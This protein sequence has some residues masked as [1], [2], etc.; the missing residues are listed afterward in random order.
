[1]CEKKKK[2]KKEKEKG[3]K[4]KDKRMKVGYKGICAFK[5]R[6]AA[7]FVEIP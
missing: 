2:L 7:P 6:I 4:Y 1:M 5:K 3:E